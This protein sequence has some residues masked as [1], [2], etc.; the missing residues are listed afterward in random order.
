LIWGKTQKSGGFSK[1]EN[2]SAFCVCAY[3]IVK[4]VESVTSVLLSD[5]LTFLSV[6]ICNKPVN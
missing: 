1:N 2:A 3:E 6:F 5:V 4:I